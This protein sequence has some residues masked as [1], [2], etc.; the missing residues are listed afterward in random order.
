MSIKTVNEAFDEFM[1]NSVDLDKDVV[2]G[3]THFKD[4]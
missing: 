1:Y 2:A 3:Q 4:F